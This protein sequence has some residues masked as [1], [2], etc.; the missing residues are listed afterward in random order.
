MDLRA[1]IN[2]R[3]GGVLYPIISGFG[4][5]AI[6][7]AAAENDRNKFLDLTAFGTGLRKNVLT[8]I[9]LSRFWQKSGKK[10]SRATQHTPNAHAMFRRN[11][12]HG[13]AIEPARGFKLEPD[14]GSSPRRYQLS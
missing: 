5:R 9:K 14:R 6:G 2:Q 4:P 3:E 11:V 13:K 1:E 10:I 7:G 8:R 12:P